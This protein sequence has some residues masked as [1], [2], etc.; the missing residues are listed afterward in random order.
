MVKEVWQKEL[1]GFLCLLKGAQILKNS[2][3]E[4]GLQLVSFKISFTMSILA[5]GPS[6]F[7]TVLMRLN[8]NQYTFR[9]PPDFYSKS[10]SL[11]RC[12]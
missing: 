5:R 8:I 1:F 10:S 9:M 2:H 6:F 12:D 4:V 3:Q 7:S 11:P